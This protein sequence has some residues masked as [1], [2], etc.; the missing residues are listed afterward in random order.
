MII[1]K[2]NLKTKYNIANL[3]TNNKDNRMSINK[4]DKSSNSKS[5]TDFISLI[6][7]DVYTGEF[8]IINNIKI[9]IVKLNNNF[10]Y[11]I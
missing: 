9:H 6:G 8:K 1:K 7:E 10:S 2:D 4:D 3:K 11:L 5:F